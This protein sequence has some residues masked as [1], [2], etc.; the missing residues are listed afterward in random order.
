MVQSSV[1]PTL[2]DAL[3]TPL[4]EAD[5]AGLREALWAQPKIGSGDIAA[6]F[7][8]KDRLD[9][10]D[11][12]F[13][14][15]LQEAVLHFAL[16]QDWPRNFLSDANATLQ[17]DLFAK[18]SRIDAETDFELLVRLAEQ[19][20]QCPA[21]FKAFLCREIE[22]AVLTG[23]GITRQGTTLAPRVVDAADVAYLRR[24]VFAPGA[25]G[26]LKVNFEEAEMLF[27]IKDATLGAPNDGGWQA[28]F[29]QAIANHLMAYLNYTPRTIEDAARQD[30]F[31]ADNAPR[32]GR[33]LGQ[34]ANSFGSSAFTKLFSKDALVDH[35]SAVASKHA[36]TVEEAAWLKRQIA[37]DGKTDDLE[38]ALLTFLVDEC[39]PVTD[40]AAGFNQ[41]ASGLS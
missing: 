31:I 27:R 35:A 37:H 8:A 25:G 32:A 9:P 24:L 14:E 7:A 19:A 33:F 26:S 22:A 40:R 13:S 5:M 41:A 10:V 29:V 21:S 34:M 30:A 6:L 18:D 1:F 36:I 20:E 12:L 2:I 11:P 39:A 16:K 28:L 38:K 15:F 23:K 4:T 3:R 17:V